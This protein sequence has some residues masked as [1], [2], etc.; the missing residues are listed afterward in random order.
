MTSVLKSD[1]LRD[2]LL[3]RLRKAD[4]FPTDLATKNARPL[5]ITE[6]LPSPFHLTD[7]Q[8]FMQYRE[9]GDKKKHVTGRISDRHTWL[10]CQF[11][12]E[13]CNEWEAE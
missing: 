11:S 1:W 3:D 6:V 2:F 9:L 7:T 4:S 8:Q 5:Q 12:A 10:T 13:C